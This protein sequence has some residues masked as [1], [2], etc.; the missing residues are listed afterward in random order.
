MGKK[1][2]FITVSEPASISE[3]PGDHRADGNWDFGRASVHAR[4]FRA[5]KERRC[6]QAKLIRVFR[7]LL[8]TIRDYLNAWAWVWRATSMIVWFEVTSEFRQGRGP[9]N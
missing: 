2:S 4:A 1:Q 9:R 7:E 6:Q 3:K 5:D 8:T